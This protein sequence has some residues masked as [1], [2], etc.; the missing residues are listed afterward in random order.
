MN[1]WND[2][3]VDA[4][5]QELHGSKPPDLSARVLLAMQQGPRGQLPR[6]LPPAPRRPWLLVALLLAAILLGVAA[7][8][9]ATA[10]WPLRQ[11]GSEDTVAVGLDVL[12]GRVDCVESGVARAVVA[13]G[14]QG[15]AFVARPGNRL[16]T[17]RGSSFRLQSFGLLVTEA[18][19]ELEVRSMEFTKKGGVVA[20]SSLTLAVAAGVVTWHSLTHTEAV[21][22]GEVLRMQASNQAGSGDSAALVAENERLRQQL[23]A[24][25]KQNEDLLAA[26]SRR[27]AMPAVQTP[28]PAEAPAPSEPALPAVSA[29]MAFS[30]PKY[31]DALAKIDWTKIGEVTQEMGPLLT[32]LAEALAKEGAELP[33]D[34]AM[35]V[36]QLNSKLLEPVAA[37]LA[38]GVPG[39]GPNGSYTHP[40]VVAN[41]MASALAAAG[42]ALTPAQQQQIEGLVRAFSAEGQSIADAQ[43]EFPYEQ[44]AAEIE[45]KDRFF[46][47]VGSLLAPE[48]HGAL[49]PAG[50][51]DYEGT[52]LFSTG[53][54][55]RAYAEPV[56][57]KDATDFARIVGDKIGHELGLD[58]NAAAQVRAVLAQTASDPGLWRDPASPIETSQA[59]FLRTGR[60]QTALR[61]Q[62]AWLRAIQQQVSLTAEQ[63]KKLGKI[64]VQVPLPR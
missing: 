47:E 5:L 28:A 7:T 33:M 14:T 2:R 13:G 19:T 54:L 58:D 57:A 21:S 22:A 38:A 63:K 8:S 44:L 39:F 20:A 25:T 50:A 36:T 56:Q 35:K 34:V 59:H 48:Q 16:L 9:A 60:T 37:L 64:R 52:S 53:V 40:L 30:D 42:H 10:W 15:P 32:Q 46:K 4:A 51:T 62:V 1:D 12:A 49:Y 61:A 6:V 3:L 55:T 11:P 45:M 31:A 18:N 43:H 17:P 27:D 23:A 29:A 24:V 26:V 41:S